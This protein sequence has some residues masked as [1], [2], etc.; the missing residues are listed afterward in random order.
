[1]PTA[2]IMPSH[3]TVSPSMSVSTPSSASPA[4]CNLSTSRRE[5]LRSVVFRRAR[6]LLVRLGHIRRQRVLVNRRHP[7]LDIIFGD[8]DH[9][10]VARKRQGPVIGLAHAVHDRGIILRRLNRMIADCK[11]WLDGRHN[12]AEGLRL[13][14]NPGRHIGRLPQIPAEVSRQGLGRQEA[15]VRCYVRLL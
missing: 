9:H 8:I 13:G 10:K 11:P 14:V 15:L 2:H 12:L 4:A 1:M 5:S 6:G 3:V 7:H